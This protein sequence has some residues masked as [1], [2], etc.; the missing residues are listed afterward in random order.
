MM[1]RAVPRTPAW[2]YLGR[3]SLV[4]PPP[5]SPPRRIRVDGRDVWLASSPELLVSPSPPPRDMCH[6]YYD[7]AVLGD[8]LWLNYID[9]PHDAMRAYVPPPCTVYPEFFDPRRYH[10]VECSSAIFDVDVSALVAATVTW[11]PTTNNN[12]RVEKRIHFP[13]TSSVRLGST[14]IWFSVLPIDARV[15]VLY[16]RMSWP[17]SWL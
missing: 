12:E 1:N 10:T 14:L 8:M 5:G 3:A 4:V 17:K 15:S 9:A 7:Y 11:W 16:V 6:A 13:C 2:L